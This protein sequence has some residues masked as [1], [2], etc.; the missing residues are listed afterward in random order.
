MSL[1]ERIGLEGKPLFKS[2]FKQHNPAAEWDRVQKEGPES[3]VL[4]PHAFGHENT[5][6]KEI[7]DLGQSVSDSTAQKLNHSQD[8]AYNATQG[9]SKNLVIPKIAKSGISHSDDSIDTDKT[10]EAG[11]AKRLARAKADILGRKLTNSQSR[12]I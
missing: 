12:E 2:P 9:F 4:G 10:R 3:P 11:I 8:S 5:N 7:H 6:P 1:L